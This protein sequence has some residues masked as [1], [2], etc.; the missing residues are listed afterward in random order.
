M[1]RCGLGEVSFV[2]LPGFVQV[3][4]QT[5]C[6]S[7]ALAFY[8][9]SDATRMHE[10]KRRTE[11]ASD[12]VLQTVST[13]NPSPDSPPALICSISHSPPCFAI[14]LLRPTSSSAILWPSATS[15]RAI[16][17]ASLPSLVEVS[18]TFLRR[19]VAAPRLTAVGLAVYRKS[20]IGTTCDLS[21]SG[22]AKDA[23][24]SED[25]SN[26]ASRCAAKESAASDAIA[27]APRIYLDCQCAKS[28]HGGE[29]EPTRI[30]LIASWACSTVLIWIHSIVWGSSSWS[31]ISIFLSDVRIDVR[32][33]AA[34]S[35][36]WLQLIIFDPDQ[37]RLGHV[38]AEDLAQIR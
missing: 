29:R 19:R 8:I 33:M 38:Y 24:E 35:S 37:R 20:R 25:W 1:V 31:I 4:D 28:R 17:L 15:S 22:E 27:G 26:S 30:V 34:V 13:F 7:V 32:A 9:E 6:R 21:A 16:I 3:G 36:S 18:R 10:N 2:E 12:P 11:V 14:S 5:Q 23:G